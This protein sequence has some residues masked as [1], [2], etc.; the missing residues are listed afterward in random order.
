VSHLIG[1]A[2]YVNFVPTARSIFSAASTPTTETDWIRIAVV[3]GVVAGLAVAVV[4]GVVS[5]FRRRVPI[6]VSIASENMLARATVRREASEAVVRSNANVVMVDAREKHLKELHNA[7]KRVVLRHEPHPNN[8]W[9]T[10]AY[11]SD[12]THSIHF[13]N[14]SEYQEHMDR[15][16]FM[17]SHYYPAPPVGTEC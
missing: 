1:H 11:Y 12:G 14:A 8:P 15:S 10:V 5:W 17:V 6:A 13:A 9:A 4:L 2:F 7:G 16:E 3:G